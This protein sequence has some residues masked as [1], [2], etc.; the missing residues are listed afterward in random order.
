MA[1]RSPSSIIDGLNAFIR[2]RYM[3]DDL[4]VVLLNLANDNFSLYANWRW[5]TESGPEIAI[6]DDQVYLWTPD[7][8]IN[9]ILF[10]YAFNKQSR[11][12]ALMPVSATPGAVAKSDWP[13]LFEYVPTQTMA[14]IRVWPKPPVG[15][16]EAKLVPIVKKKHVR[17]DSS[18]LDS[19]NTLEYPDEY[20][21]IFSYFLLDVL[22]L[23]AQV[24]ALST[25]AM[26]GRNQEQTSGMLA[27]AYQ[28]ADRIV[29]TEGL[30]VD[31]VGRPMSQ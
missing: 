1:S 3:T 19:A 21:H 9:R 2:G 27:R 13:S 4:R 7:N 8:E 16:S 5:L 26:G 23:Y 22:Y 17:I 24:G 11:I 18:N 6:T 20:E 31:S 29:E 12:T 30:F 25:V 28:A 10:V 15:L 14:G